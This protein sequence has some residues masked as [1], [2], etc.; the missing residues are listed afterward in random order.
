MPNLPPVGHKFK[1]DES[2]VNFDVLNV[3]LNFK[4]LELI[5]QFRLKTSSQKALNSFVILVH[6]VCLVDG[7]HV[8]TF[9]VNV[10]DIRSVCNE[11]LKRF[12]LTKRVIRC[13][14]QY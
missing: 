11:N 5:E 3:L 6:T 2:S 13:A 1:A 8:P 9:L 7:N 4:A 10:I 12:A 14:V